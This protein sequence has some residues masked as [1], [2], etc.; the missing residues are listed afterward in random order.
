NKRV[1]IARTILWLMRSR[2]VNVR[3]IAVEIA[4]KVG[5]PSGDLAP[6][7]LRHLRDEDWWV[8]ERVMDALVEMSGL[9]LACHLVE[10]LQDPSDVVRRYAIGALMRIKD[11]RTVGALVRVAM[12]D[13][14]WWVREEAVNAV[15]ALGDA[16]VVPYLVE[17][18][19]KHKELRLACVQAL[20][21][22]GVRQAAPH[23]ANLLKDADTP[24]RLAIV[25]CLGVLDDRAQAFALAAFQ[26]DED[27]EVQRAV[28][29]LLTRWEMLKE[30]RELGGETTASMLDK[31]LVA[32]QKAGGDDLL[33]ASTQV[34]YM[35][36]LG[37]MTPLSKTMLTEEQVRAILLPIL[38]PVQIEQ[39]DKLR[40]V[41]FS[42]E[43]KS[44]KL[45]FRV[46]VFSQLAGLSAVFRI[47]KNDVPHIDSLG[48]PDVV[49]SFG[50]MKNGLVLVGGPT[51]SGKSTTLAAL[52]DFIN[53]TESRHI[54][55]LED[56]IEV[57]HEP[58]QSLVNQREIGSH[59]RS[60]AHALRSTLREDPDV[61]LVGEMR[62]YTT[63]AFA[64]TAAE[65]GHLVFGT[66]H[67]SSADSAVDRLINAFPPAQQPQVR[68][69]LAQSLR[70]VVC[71][72][73][74]RRKGDP[75][76]VLAMEVMINNDAIANL[77][78]KGKAFQIAS[79][80]ATSRDAGMQLMD[81]EL[82]RLVREGQ[83]HKEEA[84]MKAIDK[85]AFEALLSDQRP[86]PQVVPRQAAGAA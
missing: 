18:M 20:Q 27:L 34:P 70:A 86:P 40:D 25:R 54:I 84:F 1:D 67:T 58:N 48:L 82:A 29:E 4:R 3:R 69:M 65:T 38:T 43:V 8:R 49:R 56:P 61:I 39:L 63:I 53:R 83:V 85:K 66:V 60:F 31:M 68:A 46:H 15:G 33:V 76:R 19:G 12:G 45:R 42:Y 23:V 52:I 13:G 35:K 57:V 62:D 75:G 71:Q 41:D 14:D 50:R 16:Q 36:H 26:Q 11:P 59:T 28:A 47:V 30:A 10:F 21:Q 37:A 6:K 9:A 24:L 77:I 5:D 32:V 80:I 64:V 74:L 78:R 22:L 51:G 2:D 72:H 55:S 17:L 79:T 73:L 44:K 7:L 81:Q